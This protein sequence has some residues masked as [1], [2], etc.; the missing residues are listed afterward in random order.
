MISVSACSYSLDSRSSPSYRND[1]N[2]SYNDNNDSNNNVIILLKLGLMDFI[3]K[4]ETEM[5]TFR[6]ALSNEAKVYF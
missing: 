4:F 6:C 3:Y 5:S 1:N 2:N